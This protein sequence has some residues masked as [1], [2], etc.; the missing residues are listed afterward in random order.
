MVWSEST[1][2]ELEMLMNRAAERQ[3]KERIDA[4]IAHW[5]TMHDRE[6]NTDELENI[7]TSYYGR[8]AEYE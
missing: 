3:A 6:P 1:K 8:F 7:V 4:E 5:Q 2:R